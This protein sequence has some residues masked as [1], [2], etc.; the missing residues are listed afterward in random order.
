M[1]LLFEKVDNNLIVKLEGEFDLNTAD[2]FKKEV[3][4]KITAGNKRLILDLEGVEFIDSSGLGAIL[5]K[6][7]V[8][9]KEGGYLV[10]VNLTPQVKRIFEVSGILKLLEIYSSRQE[11]LD[12]IARR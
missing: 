1:Q 4:K 7:K 2:Y 8:L 5:S 3:G 11:A 9:N 10:A 12:N 6:Y